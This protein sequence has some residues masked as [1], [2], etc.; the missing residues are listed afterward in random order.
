MQI[1]VSQLLKASIGSTR[2]YEVSGTVDFGNGAGSKVQDEVTLTHTGRGVLVKGALH[3]EVEVTCGRCLNLFGCPLALNIEEE[4]FPITDVVSGA[5]L[6]SPE[7]PGCFTIDERH[8]L[9]L[10]E[11]IRQYMLL[12]I[13]MKPLCGEDCAGLC[14]G[15]GHNLNQGLCNCL[16]QGTWSHSSE[17]SEMGSN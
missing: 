9:D 2:N 11:A 15:C 13:P 17:L 8:I 7:E 10:T 5:L 6:P 14:P 3:T 12:A 4:Y 16:P 1:N